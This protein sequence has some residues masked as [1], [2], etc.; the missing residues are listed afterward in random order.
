MWF[1]KHNFRMSDILYNFGA[2]GGGNKF[3]FLFYW[4]FF[5][6]NS[7]FFHTTFYSWKQFWH[8]MK[9]VFRV[10]LTCYWICFVSLYVDVSIDVRI[11]LQVCEIVVYYYRC[12]FMYFICTCMYNVHCTMTMGTVFKSVRDFLFSFFFI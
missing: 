10:F 7:I 3:Y 11:C 8:D 4:I 6:Q 9:H 5:K 12:I 2:K 1:K